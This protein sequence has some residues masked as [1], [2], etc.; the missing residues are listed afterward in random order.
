MKKMVSAILLLALAASLAACGTASTIPASSGVSGADTPN[1]SAGPESAPS[2]EEPAAVPP[3]GEEACLPAFGK[4]LWDAYQQGLLPDGSVLDYDGT[5]SAADQSFALADV[6]GD[7]QEEL[8]LF[9]E[10]ATMAG[11]MG[12]VFGCDG[13]AVYEELVEFP[14]LT[15]YDNGIVQAEWSHNQGLAGEFWPYNLYRYDAENDGYQFVGSVDAWDKRVSEKDYESGSFPA[16]IDADGDGVVY[17][18]RSADWDGREDLPLV[19]GP[20]Y[21]SWRAAYLDG[22]EKLDIPFQ[23]LTEEHISALGYPKPDV[24]AP[25]PVG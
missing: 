11:M 9:W 1:Q 17:Y 18:L 23:K 14:A 3:S 16:D 7:G 15:F 6:D 12:V 25:Q 10:N 4:V 2:F 24:P 19:D 22:A 5:E 20:D 8:L 13:G 21:E